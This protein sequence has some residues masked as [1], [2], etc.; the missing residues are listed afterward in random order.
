[1]ILFEAMI[2]D[3]SPDYWGSSDDVVG[4]LH[5]D[6]NFT[7]N[8]IDFTNSQSLSSVKITVNSN[9][10]HDGTA[11]TGV[12]LKPTSGTG[13]GGIVFR[14]A[15]DENVCPLIILVTLIR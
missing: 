14:I 3:A 5:D 10:R 12:V 2:D 8:V 11:D 7:D 15:I 13:S 6:S 1:M 4:E 9:D